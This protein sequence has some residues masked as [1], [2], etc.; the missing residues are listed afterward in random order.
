M[1]PKIASGRGA[2]DVATRS[3]SPGPLWRRRAEAPR[4]SLLLSG[5]CERYFLNRCRIWSS[6][7][8]IQK[9]TCIDFIRAPLRRTLGVEMVNL[10]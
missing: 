10:Q 2:S 9:N 8:A 6:R 3:A 5:Y 7:V 1:E 4:R